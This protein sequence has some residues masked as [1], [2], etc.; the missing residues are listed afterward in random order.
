MRV[1]KHCRGLAVVAACLA[2]PTAALAT[3]ITVTTTADTLVTDGAC[4]IREAIINANNDATTWPDCAAGAGADIINLPAGTI[5]FQI[6][7]PP[8]SPS[9]MDADQ[10][11]AMGDLDLLSSMTINGHSA[12]TVIDGNQLDRVFDIN[13]DVDSL[14]ETVTPVITVQ[15][16]DLTMTNARQNQSGAVRIML[17][18]TVTMDRCTVSNSVSWADDGG[19][20]RVGGDDPADNGALTTNSPSAATR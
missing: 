19:G 4:S 18:A 13:P 8:S 9:N 14:P 10:V 16:N 15:I 12:G 17:R 11:A 7:N 2:L 20:S 3:T 6:P 5:T 1:P